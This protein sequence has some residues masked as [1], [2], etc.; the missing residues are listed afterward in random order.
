MKN[1]LK[2]L[3]FPLFASLLLAVS[4]VAA[5]GA[6]PE[7]AAPPVPAE[8]P[9]WNVEAAFGGFAGIFHGT[10]FGG[11][12]AALRVL[13]RSSGGH[14]FGLMLEPAQG[15]QGQ[16]GSY[17]ALGI[18]GYRYQARLLHVDVLPVFSAG[19]VCVENG[20]TEEY[21]YDCDDHAGVG[22][23]TRVGLTGRWRFLH[24]GLA[25]EVTAAVAPTLG[26]QAFLGAE[27]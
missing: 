20:S 15:G 10:T 18:V 22:V 13:Y 3:V 12:S 9:D 19:E 2:Y 1:Y 24:F 25:L 17:L 8:R 7:G 23:R 11:L 4:S 21:P 16:D 26:A 27:F 14:H 5:H 6:P